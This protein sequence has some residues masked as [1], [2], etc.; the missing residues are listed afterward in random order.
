MPNLG[1]IASSKSGNLASFDYESISTVN[2]G[3]GGSSSVTLSS[4]PSTFTHLQVRCSA[5]FDSVANARMRFNGDTG[6]NYSYHTLYGSSGGVNV[7]SGSSLDGFYLGGSNNPG[8]STSMIIDI[9][10]YA[11]ANKYKVNRTFYG[12]EAN[13][14]TGDIG[15][16]TGAWLSTSAI[17]SITIYGLTFQQNSS[18]A[19]YGIKG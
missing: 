10:D 15:Y 18:F 9:L 12:T 19:L 4:I 14:T 5:K 2:V 13:T 6:S 1:I 11:N 17:T 8:Y 16:R 3:S 7:S